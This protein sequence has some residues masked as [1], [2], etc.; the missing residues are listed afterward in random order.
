MQYQ[1]SIHRPYWLAL[2]LNGCIAFL[3]CLAGVAETNPAP[4]ALRYETRTAHDPNGIGKFYLG[5]EIAQVMGHQGADWL[6]RPEREQ[7][8]RTD[9]LLPALKLKPGDT[10]ADIGAGTGYYTR[11][12]AQAVGGPLTRPA[13]TLSPSDG[14]REGVRGAFEFFRSSTFNSAN[15]GAVPQKITPRCSTS[16]VAVE[17][18]QPSPVC[19][20]CVTVA[21]N[22]TASPSCAANVSG[23]TCRPS[24]KENFGARSFATSPLF[25]RARAPKIWPLIIEP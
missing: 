16:P 8:E 14:E 9:L 18:R 2:F 13:D 10:V 1:R 12:L 6:E 11:K 7:E 15:L 17:T 22:F 21:L 5:R 23:K 25:F 3:T 20:S 19:V 24:S 4:P